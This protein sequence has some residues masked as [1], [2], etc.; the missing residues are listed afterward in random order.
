M[1]FLELLT[2]IFI[3]LKV[4]GVIAWSWWLVFIPMYVAVALYAVI[5]FFYGWAFTRT[6]KVGKKEYKQMKKDFDKF[7]F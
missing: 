1:G 6:F 4:F 3:L 7:D 2:V 5:I